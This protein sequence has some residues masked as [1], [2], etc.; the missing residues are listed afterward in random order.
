M[1]SLSPGEVA[2]VVKFAIPK[3]IVVIIYTGIY[4]VIVFTW[5]AQDIIDDKAKSAEVMAWCHR[6][7]EPIL[8]QVH[9]TIWCHHATTS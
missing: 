7:P 2:L 4:S 6:A 9:D 3:C 8:P 1:K 5:M